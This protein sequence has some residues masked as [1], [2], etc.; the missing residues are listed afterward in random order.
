[1]WNQRKGV[2]T[3]SGGFAFSFFQKRP[4]SKRNAAP[5]RDTLSS[6]KVCEPGLAESIVADC[7]QSAVVEFMVTRGWQRRRNDANNR[8]SKLARRSQNCANRYPQIGSKSTTQAHPGTARYPQ[9]HRDGQ[10]RQ[11]RVPSKRPG[12]IE[13]PRG[14]PR[15]AQEHPG[16]P[17]N[18]QESPERPSSAQGSPGRPLTRRPPRP[19]ATQP[20]TCLF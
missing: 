18:A 2:M 12:E 19:S 16:S 14:A 15:T 7:S 3:V 9:V 13:Q 5:N 20:K 17:R 1:M 6:I 4:R 10:V 11:D 8:Q